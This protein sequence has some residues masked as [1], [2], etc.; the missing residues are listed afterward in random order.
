MAKLTPIGRNLRKLM[1]SSPIRGKALTASELSRRSGVPQ[2]TISRIL[3]GDVLDPRSH[4]LR[5]LATYFGISLVSLRNESREPVAR[6][7]PAGDFLV[8]LTDQEI[9]LIKL[10]RSSDDEGRAKILRVAESLVMGNK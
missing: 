2:S 6:P 8:Y 9:T 3:N 4:Q 1:A 10:F 5:R 7:R